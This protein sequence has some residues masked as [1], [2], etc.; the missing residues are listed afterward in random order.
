MLA[1]RWH[2]IESLYHFARELNP[3][4]RRAYLENACASD[5]ALRRE[6]ESLLAREELAA[7]FLE[8][9]AP[10]VCGKAGEASV[11]AGE[12]IGPYLVLEFLRKGGMGEVYKARDTRLDRTVAMKFLPLAFAD[13]HA[14]LDRFQREARAAS[15]L[16]HPRICTVHDVGDYHSRP[17]FVMEFLEGQSLRDRIAGK[18]LPIRELV[19]FAVQICEA[20]QAAH[21]RGIIHRDIKPG[22]IFVTTSGQVKILDFGLA[23]LVTDPRPAPTAAKMAESATTVTSATL[24]RPGALMGTPTYLS[25]EQARCE[26]V[27][28]RTD[29]FSLGVVLFEMATG[30]PSFRGKTSGELIGAILH[31]TPAKPSTSNPAVPAGLEQ[32]ILRMLEKERTARYQSAGDLLADLSQL[33]HASQRHSNWKG[34]L[35]AAFAA[36]VIVLGVVIAMIASKQSGGGVPDIVQRQITANPASDSVYLAAISGDGKQVAYSDLQGVHVRVID[37]GEV[38]NVPLPP[39]FCFR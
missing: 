29:I 17:F 3:E 33:Q 38:Y 21:A 10:A 36:L 13:D 7:N 6:V 39:G 2:K 11:P 14:A 1:E 4:E 26:E 35:A 23:K 34:R 5:E 18:P 8:T 27:D 30:R 31:Q 9:D 19:D 16:N 37:T 20:L 22:N 28:A 12:R 24:T 32:I 25:P 15:A